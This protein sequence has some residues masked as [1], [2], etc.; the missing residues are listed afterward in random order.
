MLSTIFFNNNHINLSSWAINPD[1]IYDYLFSLDPH[2]GVGPDGI[3]SVFLKQCCSVLVKPL[4]F[5][6]NKSLNLGYFPDSWKKSFVT[7]IHK[8]GDKHNITNIIYW[9][10]KN[11][12]IYN[13]TINVLF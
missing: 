5:I 13:S 7:P 12:V 3:P 11:V 4:H 2:A 8:T 10:T 1:E 9:L 6:F